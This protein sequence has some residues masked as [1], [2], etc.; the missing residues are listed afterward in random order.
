MDPR[1]LCHLHFFTEVARHSEENIKKKI[2]IDSVRNDE[3]YPGSSL[4]QS[5]RNVQESIAKFEDTFKYNVDTVSLSSLMN[6]TLLYFR[7]NKGGRDNSTS[8][9]KIE[10]I[11]ALEN[12]LESISRQHLVSGRIAQ[13][14]AIFSFYTHVSN[15]STSRLLST[16]KILYLD[17]EGSEFHVLNEAVDSGILM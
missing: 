14:H 8:M 2:F 5:H 10:E 9:T 6:Q 13:F 7:D 4:F 3:K 11:E 17:I 12:D 1:P 15:N 16:M